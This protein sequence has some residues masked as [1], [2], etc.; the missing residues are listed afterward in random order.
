M[1]DLV[2]IATEKVVGSHVNKDIDA[3]LIASAV[4]ESDR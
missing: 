2:E 1:V 4:K 3:K